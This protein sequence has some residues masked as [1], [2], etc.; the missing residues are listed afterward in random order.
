MG[1]APPDGRCGNAPRRDREL[2][3]TAAVQL[4]SFLLLF[5]PQNYRAT[6]AEHTALRCMADLQRKGG[7]S[8]WISRH[9]KHRQREE[10]PLLEQTEIGGGGQ[11]ECLGNPMV[12][13]PTKRT[14]KAKH[15]MAS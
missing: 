9:K 14:L 8:P 1:T 11:H 4:L 2:R 12:T 13:I 5:S 7:T 3:R 10:Q 15:T 6:R